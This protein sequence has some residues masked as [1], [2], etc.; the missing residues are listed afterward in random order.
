MISVAHQPS[1]PV[2]GQTSIEKD[3]TLS[4]QTILVIIAQRLL[5]RQE[6]E[7]N[8]PGPHIET[9]K[10]TFISFV[11]FHFSLKFHLN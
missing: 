1:F 10:S 8:V 2:E 6:W 3:F 7:E 5:R 11:C 9:E 4:S